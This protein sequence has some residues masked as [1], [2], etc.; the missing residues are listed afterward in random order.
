MARLCTIPS[1]GRSCDGTPEFEI[2]AA[3]PEDAP[4]RVLARIPASRVP[5]W[6]IVNPALS[7]DGKWLAQ[8]LT[9][10]FTTNVWALSGVSDIWQEPSCL[11]FCCCL[12]RSRRRHRSPGFKS[13]VT[14]VEVDVVVTDKSGRPVRG[15][16]RED[17]EISEDGSPVEIATFSAVDV[18]EAPRDS[19]IPPPDRSG[20]AFASN[21]QA[22][23][24]RLILIVL[25]DIQVS[26]T[27]GRMAT[28]KSVARR[29]VER[30]GPADLAAVMTTSGRLGGQTEFTTDK[31]RL[32]DA[33]E[34]FVPQGEHDLP[35]IADA[36][37]SAP[38]ANP[39]AQ[40]IGE[41]RTRSAM[42]GLSV[43]ARALAT[44]PHR[45]KG[46]LLISQGFPATLEEIIRDARIG[47]AYES[48]REFIL[49][50]QR[51]NVAVYTVDPCGL[52]LDAGCNRASRQNLRTIAEAHG[53]VRR[54]QHESRQK[55]PSIGCLLRTV[56]TT[57]LAITRRL[58]RT[59]AS[60][61]ESRYGHELRMSRSVHGRVTIHRGRLRKR[62]PR[63]RS[64]S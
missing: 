39:R 24:G 1:S 26:F 27:A 59:T 15:L 6:Q 16:R 56:P 3:T 20:S 29:A 8:A 30:L 38:G 58:R 25:D 34:R 21:D 28:V 2:R 41:L 51:S 61:I 13:G 5:I 54:D 44:I 12:R 62:S 49:T 50:A 60:I 7:P 63:L 31:S 42:A 43:A 36:L 19:I 14:V 23:D 32:L 64:R 45:R 53:R 18:P 22:D 47:A 48:I 55:R 17:F 33:I 4:F 57:W 35:A 11:P 46:V 40:R 37:P 52:E 9:D 10:G